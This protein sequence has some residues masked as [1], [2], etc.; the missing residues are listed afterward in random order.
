M[1][2]SSKLWRFESLINW[3]VNLN[4]TRWRSVVSI[5]DELEDYESIGKKIDFYPLFTNENGTKVKVEV[6]EMKNRNYCGWRE[7][8]GG[9][10]NP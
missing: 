3:K 8:K 10:V 7:K 1:E 9:A 6:W 5:V 4:I 2:E